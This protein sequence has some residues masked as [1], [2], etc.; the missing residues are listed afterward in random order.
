M[1]DNSLFDKINPALVMADRERVG[2]PPGP[3]A[4]ILDSQSVKPTGSG[5]PRG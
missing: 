1:R 2:R 3:T 5:G 4:A